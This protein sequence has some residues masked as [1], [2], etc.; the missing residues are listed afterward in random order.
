V[1]KRISGPPTAGCCRPAW[2]ALHRVCPLPPCAAVARADVC[3]ASKSRGNKVLTDD[4][5]WTTVKPG[6][7]LKRR[8]TPGEKL[9]SGLDEFARANGITSAVIVS[10]IGSITDLE[11]HNLCGATGDG[12]FEFQDHDISSVLE[13]VSAEGHIAPLPG[14]D[15]RTHIHIVAAKG[16]GEVIGGHCVDAT[17]CTSGYLFLQVLVNE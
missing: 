5:D 2:Y 11:L 4:S 9:V 7:L 6:R 15:I 10:C 14:G 13:I 16:S 12:D 17:I 8:F 1:A 3:P